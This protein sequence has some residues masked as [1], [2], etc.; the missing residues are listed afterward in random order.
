MFA[1]N[2]LPLLLS[3]ST[4]QALAVSFL[5]ALM[6]FQFGTGTVA[7]QDRAG[8]EILYPS[9]EFSKLDTFEGLNLEDADKLYG[10]KDYKGAYAAYKAYSF[11]FAKS[12][13]LPYVLLR[14][15]RCLQ[16]VEKRNAAIK[17]YQ[18]VVDYFPDD[19]RYAAGALYYMGECHGLNGD[20]AKQTATWARMVKDDD[21]VTQPNSGTALTYLGN[22][23]EKLGKH[24]QAAE[25]HWRTAVAFLKSN[26]RAAAS[27]RSA[28]TAHYVRRNLNHD[29]LK[30][31][32]IA[33]SGFDGRGNN[34]QDPEEDGRYWTTVLGT[35]IG[36]RGEAA[37]REKI[38]AYWGA[39]MGDRFEEDDALRKLWCDVLLISE[40]APAGW[41]ARMDKQFAEKPAEMNRVLQWCDYYTR[42]AEMRSEFFAKQSKSFIAGM[43]TDEK[44][45][46]MNRLRH[47]LG[48][49]DEAQ[50]VMR[51]IRTEGMD[52]KQ[53]LSYAGFVA[54]YE[55]EETVFRYYARLKDK[56]LATKARFDYYNART[57]R[58]P[59]NMEKALA[60]IP[61]L[62]KDPDY[63]AGLVMRQAQL[64]QG[65]GRYEEAIKSYR[66]AN[67]QPASTWGITDCQVALKQFGG[68]VKTAQGLESVGGDVAAQA[69]FKVA[70]IYRISGDKGKE[71]TQLRTVLKRYPKS[72][73][74]S[75][76]HNRLETYGVA[77]VGGEAEAEE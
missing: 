63:A 32:Y 38:C 50:V 30:E 59:P 25:Y 47:P 52:D 61:A 67:E 37:L 15:A 48:M 35:A 5:V 39:K 45:A 49:H 58:N 2:Q 21:Y 76:A 20:D 55:P 1:L 17:A 73:Q 31:F 7:A 8:D 13:A 69:C 68:A 64:Q 6:V 72:K 4:K 11:E 3:A 77:L 42:D 53:L 27:A 65:L 26:E 41:L 51:S 40:K 18:D 34:T 10:K 12:K 71:V 19:V 46:L 16:K 66:T 43:K 44:M 33:A 70:D 36:T 74:S 24:E 14:M 75:E 29:K 28:V 62:L 23:M 22:A 56:P 9:K 54:N 57:H 60:E